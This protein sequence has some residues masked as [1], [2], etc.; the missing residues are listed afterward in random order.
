MTDLFLEKRGVDDIELYK[1]VCTELP[2]RRYDAYVA[3]AA[4]MRESARTLDP[5]IVL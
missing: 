5:D 2:Q 4:E 1:R 3:L